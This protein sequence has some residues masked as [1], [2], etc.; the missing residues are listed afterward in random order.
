[1]GVL[2]QV[3]F[4]VLLL[5]RHRHGFPCLYE[6][7]LDLDFMSSTHSLHFTLS[8][9]LLI[10]L[11]NRGFYPNKHIPFIPVRDDASETEEVQETEV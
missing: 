10:F 8:F 9:C 1:L 2:I 6:V 3:I 5:F 11:F 4:K 7:L